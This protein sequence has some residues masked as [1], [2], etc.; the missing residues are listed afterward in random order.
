M[1]KRI[2]VVGTGGSIAMR[3]AHSLDLVDYGGRG[4]PR[5]V[6]EMLSLLPEAEDAADL[7]AVDFSAKA[8]EAV[9]PA[10]WIDWSRRLSEL[11]SG[12]SPP[13]GV[14]ILH[15]TST[16]EETA[17]FLDLTMPR[18]IP[19]V[20]TGAMR[21]LGT[22]GSDAGRNLLDAI[23]AAADSAAA[24][25]GVLVVANGEIHSARDVAKAST[26]DLNAFESGRRGR[27]GTVDA[28]GLV[29]LVRS[30]R[31]RAAPF[32]APDP[33]RLPRIDIVFAYAGADGCAV[34]AATQAESRGIVLAGLAPGT[35]APEQ[36]AAL[37]RAESQGLA[38][39]MCSRGGQG[40]VID[41]QAMRAQGFIAG[42]DLSP[43][44]ARV[45]LMLCIANGADSGQIREHFA[46]A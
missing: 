15:G 4:A 13:D 45:L 26:Y 37:A 36:W 29:R 33:Y 3:P 25:Q 6:A 8:S 27:L 10:D 44:K 11:T 9:N 17:W 39:V 31:R 40:R 46:S 23:R 21:P 42:N 14:V 12:G 43:Q 35:C 32:E 1:K 30:S 18:N 2:L 28:D 24:G 5:S 22:M 7:Q 41:S 16:L 34:D 20:A 19:I 38:V